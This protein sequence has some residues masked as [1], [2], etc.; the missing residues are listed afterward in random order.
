MLKKIVNLTI[1]PEIK[2]AFEAKVGRGNVSKAVESFMRK[3][4]GG[5]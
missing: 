3:E 1:D 5:K 4:I 2:M